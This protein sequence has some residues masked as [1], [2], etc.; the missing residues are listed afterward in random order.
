MVFMPPENLDA[1]LE[2]IGYIDELR[3]SLRHRVAEPRRWYGGLRRLVFTKA[4]Q[5]SNSIEGYNASVDDVL[6][7]VE[8]EESFDATTE[9]RLALQGYR[10]AMTYVLQLADENDLDVDESLLKALHYMMLK[11]ELS[12]RP[13]RWR[14]GD[15]YV[16][17]EPTG[18]IV[19]EGPDSERVPALIDDLLACLS[20]HDGPVLIR[21]ALAHLNLVMIH[22]FKDGNGRMGRCLQT[23]VLAREQIVVPVFSSIEEQLG[24]DT[25]SYYAVLGQVGEGS[26]HPEHDSRPWIRFCLNAHYRQAQRVLRRIQEIEELW[27]RCEQL[28]DERRLPERSVG[29]LCDASRGM[30]I[31]NWTYRLAVEES[32]GDDIDPATASRDLR[33][34]VHNGLLEPRGETRGRFYVGT[35]ELRAVRMAIRKKYPIGRR[36]VDLFKDKGTRQLDLGLAG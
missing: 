23:L 11:H 10:D 6:A 14:T 18:E 4:V 15:V 20:D 26:W 3:R 17:R 31:H 21:A 5:G 36:P 35:D 34:L 16:R 1:E 9:T 29:A 19:Y 2:A 33:S 25:E 22:P 8:D 27:E 13:G 32:Y 24:R 30:R 28:A 12:K 7:V